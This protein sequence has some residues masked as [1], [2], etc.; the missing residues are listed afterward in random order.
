M[1]LTNKK[2]NLPGKP[3]VKLKEIA[4]GTQASLTKTETT[5]PADYTPPPAKQDSAARYVLAKKYNPKTERNTDTWN[6]ITTA[7]A[8]GPKTLAELT[9]AVEAHKD[10]VGYMVRGGHIAPQAKAE[11]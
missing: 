1:Q 9:K 8:D 2:I 4:P 5:P 7:L 11:G 6:K 3:P 10:F